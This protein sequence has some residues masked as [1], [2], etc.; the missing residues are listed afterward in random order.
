V[1][2]NPKTGEFR[3]G[4]FDAPRG[5]EHWLLKFDGV[6]DGQPGEPRNEGRVEYAYHLMAKAAAIRM[7]ECRLHEEGGRSHFMT[8]RFDRGPGG[9]RHH[10]QTLCAMD[11]MDFG[12]MGAY[13]YAQLFEVVHKL[14]LSEAD[15]QET[16]RR[17]AFNVMARN[18]DDHTKNISFL[19]REG[20]RWELSP[21]YDLTFAHDPAGRWNH[22]HFLA[23]NGKY[24]K[25]LRQDLLHEADRFSVGDAKGIL[26]QVRSAVGLWPK[27]AR[28]AGLSQTQATIIQGL[29]RLV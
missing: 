23:I 7:S 21:A 3:S 22:Q 18:M 14:E 13:S 1:C 19:L 11:H 2:W 25:I 10:V 12:L 8:R 17:M 24:D 6:E 15:L 5:F 9:I 16:F 28:E 20:G 26:E 4:Q 27:F 29:H